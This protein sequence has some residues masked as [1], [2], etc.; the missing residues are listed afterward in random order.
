MS[1]QDFRARV[2]AGFVL[3]GTS[4]HDWCRRNE[5]SPSYAHA[6]LSGATN[7]PAACALRE[8]LLRESQQAA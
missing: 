8:R 3:A 1:Q 5:V 7:G 6:V 2:K 4:L